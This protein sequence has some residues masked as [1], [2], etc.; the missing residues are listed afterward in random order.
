MFN[1]GPSFDAVIEISA[2]QFG[3]Q[4]QRLPVELP[5]NTRKRVV[6]PGFSV[7]PGFVEVNARLIDSSGKVLVEKTGLRLQQVAWDGFLLAGAPASF[8]GMPAFPEGVGRQNELQPRAVRLDLG[9]RLESFPDNP[10]TLEGLNGIYLNSAKALELKDPQVDALLAWVHAGGHLIVAIDQPGDVGATAWLKDI[11]PA[12]LGGLSNKQLNGELHHWLATS[13]GAGRADLQYVYQP[14]P[15]TAVQRNDRAVTRDPFL[16]LEPQA[17]FDQVSLPLV[18]LTPRAGKVLVTAGGLPLII[19]ASRGRGLVTVLAFNP[20]RDPVKAW[21]HR[22]WMWAR[23]AGVPREMLQ[24]DDANVWGGRSTDAVFGAMIE[25]RQVRKLPVGVLLLLLVV[26]LVV[27][28]PLDQ[29]WLKKINRPMLTWITFPAYVALFSLLIYYIG[30]RLRAGNSEWNELHIVEI[31]PRSGEA[32]LRGRAF[33]SLYSPANQNYRVAT[34]VALSTL[35]PESQGQWG[36]NNDSGRLAVRRKSK[37]IEADVYV[38]VWT[39]QM[40]V[41]DWQ[42]TGSAPLQGRREGTTLTLANLRGAALTNVLVMENG[43]LHRV[44]SIPAG[45]TVR[46][47]LAA[48]TRET[49]GEFV[50]NWSASLHAAATQRNEVFGS[51]GGEHIDDWA[52]ASSALSLTSLIRSEGANNGRDLVWPAGLDLAPVLSRGDVLVLAWLPNET[53]IPPMNRFTALRHQSG[54]LLRLVV[55]NPR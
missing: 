4:T 52:G 40:N 10:I 21:K 23:L 26:Y 54:T 19:C 32:V 46:V 13:S 38:P 14:P 3:S 37:G 28:G 2:G 55:P 24:K 7:S 15:M 51:G 5:T 11:L 50:Q 53:L 20:E 36:N 41:S 49:P 42:E 47:D 29:W 39:S 18:E 6:M 45:G 22:P 31:L 33:T 1:D 43:K 48:E 17:S 16:D 44:D 35:R 12:T 8:A 9:Q 25:T 34:D 27:I 30:F